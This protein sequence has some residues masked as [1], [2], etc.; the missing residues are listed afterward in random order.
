MWLP[1]QKTLNELSP[2]YR[3]LFDQ[4]HTGTVSSMKV[5]PYNPEFYGMGRGLEALGRMVLGILGA[6]TFIGF[7]GWTLADGG[8]FSFLGGM[9]T[10][11][12]YL[13]TG[14]LALLGLMALLLIIP[15]FKLINSQMQ[16]L[17]AAISSRKTQAQFGFFLFPDALVYRPE[18]NSIWVIPKIDVIRFEEGRRRGETGEVSFGKLVYRPLNVDYNLEFCKHPTGENEKPQEFTLPLGTVLN[19]LKNWK[20]T[21]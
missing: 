14:V 3:G 18:F 12:S 5:I 2:A 10:W 11:G 19:I 15:F 4:S 13:Q 8:R 21:K 20:S 9:G 6:G 1:L 7:T 16:L 17:R